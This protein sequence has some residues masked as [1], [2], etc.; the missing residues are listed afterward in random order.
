MDD[1]PVL[2]ETGLTRRNTPLRRSI[3]E[4]SPILSSPMLTRSRCGRRRL[5]HKHTQLSTSIRPITKLSLPASP[6]P[7]RGLVT[8]IYEPQPPPSPPW[9]ANCRVYLP[10]KIPTPAEL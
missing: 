1:A 5:V 3:Q 10:P 2:R 6:R 9:G 7:P 8:V 4:T